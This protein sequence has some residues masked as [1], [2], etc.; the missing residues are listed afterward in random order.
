MNTA[1]SA[2]RKGLLVRLAA[3]PVICA[4]GYLLELERRGYI[5]AGR[6]G[7]KSSS[8]SPRR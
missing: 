1:R 2:S 8:I 7:P 5:P 4:E 3:G 6:S